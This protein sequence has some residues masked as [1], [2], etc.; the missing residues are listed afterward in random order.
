MEILYFFIIDVV[1]KIFAI[2]GEFF[3]KTELL[4]RNL[5]Y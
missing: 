3:F 1:I 2:K 5:S 4:G